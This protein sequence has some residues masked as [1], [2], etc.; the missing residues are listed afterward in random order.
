MSK[1][2]WCGALIV[3][4]GAGAVGVKKYRSGLRSAAVASIPLQAEPAD[5]GHLI[6]RPPEYIPRG[7]TF[8]LSPEL[9]ALEE[10]AAIQEP[11]P[12]RPEP[13]ESM[14]KT[15]GTLPMASG[16]VE[17]CDVLA[18]RTPRPD[19]ERRRMPYAD[20]DD[21]HEFA[22][23]LCW[24]RNSHAGDGPLAVPSTADLLSW[25][26]LVRWAVK[27]AQ[28]GQAGAEESE[29]P[30]LLEPPPPHQHPPHCPFGG[31]CPYP[32]AYRHMPPRS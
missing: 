10:L 27:L 29:E 26:G 25:E 4:V 11:I 12:T 3:M 13:L 23:L 16:G 20:E 5:A 19:L 22:E 32:G 30:P 14:P 2:L 28:R 17:E 31:H 1:W 21:G 6:R 9:A 8:P 15:T 7:E 18:T 24:M